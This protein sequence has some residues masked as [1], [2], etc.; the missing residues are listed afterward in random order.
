[1]AE[2]WPGGPVELPH[3]LTI[4]GQ[5]VL[6]PEV[7]TGTLLHWLAARQW[8][9]LLPNGLAP[10]EATLLMRRCDDEDDPFDFEQLWEPGTRLFGRLA[11]TAPFEGAGTGFWPGARLASTVIVQWPLFAA[12]CRT[13]GHVPLDGPLW[14]TIASAYA[15]LRE[16]TMPERLAQ[17]EQQIWSPPPVAVAVEPQELPRHVREEEAALALKALHEAA[18]GGAATREWTPAPQS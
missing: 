17:L 11:G 4:D 5:D 13:H 15:W 10:E 18:A 2:L 14:Q 16:T 7:P 9:N 3:R 8:W 12:W 6:V 1:M